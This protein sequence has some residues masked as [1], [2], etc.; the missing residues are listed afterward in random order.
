MYDETR[1]RNMGG[2]CGTRRPSC[3]IIIIPL[4]HV[5]QNNNYNTVVHGLQHKNWRRPSFGIFSDRRR[6]YQK[7]IS[8]IVTKLSYWNQN[9][10]GQYSGRC[11]P[12]AVDG[13]TQLSA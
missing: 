1:R 13:R 12:I 3:K 7:Q 6:V 5:V 9:H 11:V 2:L 4:R 10:P 8:F